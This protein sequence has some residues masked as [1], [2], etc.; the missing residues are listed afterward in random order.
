MG[1][2]V[3]F[4]Y[5]HTPPGLACSDFNRAESPHTHQTTCVGGG[6]YQIV[7]APAT[8]CAD[9]CAADG[10]RW[11]QHEATHAAPSVSGVAA[12]SINGDART[13]IVSVTSGVVSWFESAAEEGVQ[14]TRHEIASDALGARHV[15]VLDIDGDNDQDVATLVDAPDSTGNMDLVWY[16]NDGNPSY[17]FSGPYTI[18]SDI[19]TGS[20]YS[21]AMVAG[22]VGTAPGDD[23]VVVSSE[24]TA[25]M[26]FECAHASQDC[27]ES[28]H[29]GA[30][31]TPVV[32]SVGSQ[33][34]PASDELDDIVLGDLD[35]DDDLD[36][37]TVSR[38]GSSVRWYQ[39]LG[40]N[41]W[42]KHDDTNSDRA[43]YLISSSPQT[44]AGTRLRLA[45]F[46]MNGDMG[47]GSSSNIGLDVVVSS[48]GN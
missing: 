34:I 20:G 7:E 4:M 42:S 30:S 33:H 35:A 14:W 41:Q 27:T 40:S 29:W 39:N 32:L 28:T 16:R 25:I 46:D 5:Y 31:G 48:P 22:N 12:A 43:R 21:L 44:L 15:L 9:S 6:W 23:I 3:S 1:T 26:I 8:Y 38:V 13:D 24:D 45:V 10:L 11:C 47:A 37:V 18:K 19:G 2:P 17:S 36:I